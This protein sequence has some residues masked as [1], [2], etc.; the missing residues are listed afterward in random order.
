MSPERAAKW[1][2]NGLVALSGL[3]F[4]NDYKPRALPW[5]VIGRAVGPH[6]GYVRR[7]CGTGFG[8]MAGSDLVSVSNDDPCAERCSHDRLL[9]RLWCYIVV[10]EVHHG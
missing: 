2:G 6:D 10:T 3:G 9:P 1:L 8:E 5:A 7:S 4:H